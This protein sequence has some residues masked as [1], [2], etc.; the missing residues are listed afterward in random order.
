[1]FVNTIGLTQDIQGSD[2][3]FL[4]CDVVIAEGFFGGRI[5]A[6]AGMPF[7]NFF[8]QSIVGYQILHLGW[9]ARQRTGGAVGGDPMQNSRVLIGSSEAIHQGI[10]HDFQRQWTYKMIWSIIHHRHKLDFDDL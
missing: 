9:L 7:H 3:F 4:N 5:V 6:L 8:S 2:H 1:L 10:L